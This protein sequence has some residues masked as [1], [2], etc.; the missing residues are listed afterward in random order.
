V[1][2]N[3]SGLRSE[4]RAAEAAGA[5]LDLAARLDRISGN[6]DRLDRGLRAGRGTAGRAVY[7]DEIARQLAAFQARMDSLKAELRRDPGRWLRFSLF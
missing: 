3:M 1:A 7:D 2:G 6:L 5:V 4:E